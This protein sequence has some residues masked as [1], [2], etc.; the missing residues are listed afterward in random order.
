MKRKICE[1]CHN[2]VDFKKT[3]EVVHPSFSYHTFLHIEEKELVVEVVE[4]ENVIHKSKTPIKFCPLCGRK[5]IFNYE[6]KSKT[7]P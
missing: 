4:E 1:F 6:A 5:L 7:L 2:Q 3:K